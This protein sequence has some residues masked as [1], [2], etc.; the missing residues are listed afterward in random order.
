MVPTQGLNPE[1]GTYLKCHEGGKSGNARERDDQRLIAMRF[2][3]ESRRM[4][5]AKKSIHQSLTEV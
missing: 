2:P 1:Y 3:R 5:M 4:E